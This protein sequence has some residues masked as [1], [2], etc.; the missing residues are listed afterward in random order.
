M[1][2]ISVGRIISGN[3]QI[4]RSV[5]RAVILNL[6]REHQPVSRVQL[7]KITGL[8]KSTVSSIVSDLLEEN[9]IFE[10]TGGESTGGRPPVLLRLKRRVNFVGAIDIDPEESTVAIADIDGT[11]LRKAHVDADPANPQEFARRCVEEIENLKREL[12]IT[13]LVG[14]GVSVPGIVEARRGFVVIAPDLGWQHLDLR[15]LFDNYLPGDGRVVYENEANAAALAALWFDP[16]VR[17]HSNIVFI[18]EGI[19]TGVILDGKLIDGSFSGAGQ[20]GHMTIQEQGE[21]CV[22]GNRGCWE[23]YASNLATVQRYQQLSGQTAS[24]HVQ[25]ILAEILERAKRGESN[26]VQA[27]RETGRYLGIGISNIIK[28]IDPEVIVLGGAITSCWDLIYPE[29]MK[30]VENRVFFDI[31]KNV[32]IIPTS[33]QERSSLVG[34]ATLVIKQV[35]GGYKIMK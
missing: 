5:N 14:L 17:D 7:S 28:G 11:I 13:T 1:P 10:E 4:V 29:I 9:L 24:D 32:Q 20:F 6:I 35:F 19:G 27:V 33:L 12:W 8:N 30:E 2:K 16:L 3:H 34:A 22:C 18:S 31:K 15:S 26:A 25:T 23:V 21:R